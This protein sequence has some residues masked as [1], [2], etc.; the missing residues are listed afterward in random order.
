MPATQK[1]LGVVMLVLVLIPH[2]WLSALSAPQSPFPSLEALCVRVSVST[3]LKDH[4]PYPLHVSSCLTI[5]L[6]GQETSGS[7]P[8]AHSH[9]HP[10]IQTVAMSYG[11]PFP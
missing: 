2:V 1:S 7:S 10:N 8:T 3:R 5:V 4:P 9:S 11:L 6:L